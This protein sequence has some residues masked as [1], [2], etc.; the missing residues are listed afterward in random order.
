M[1]NASELLLNRYENTELDYV[2]DHYLTVGEDS[3]IVCRKKWGSGGDFRCLDEPLSPKEAWK[4]LKKRKAAL[5]KDLRFCEEMI[6][7]LT[8]K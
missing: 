6:K 5:E 8:G 3:K 4:L 1:A 7:I 2:E